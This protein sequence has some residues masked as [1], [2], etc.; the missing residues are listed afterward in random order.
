M[1]GVRSEIQKDT[2]LYFDLVDITKKYHKSME[3]IGSTWNGSEGVPGKG[4]EMVD[5]SLGMANGGMTLHRHLYSTKHLD[6]DSQVKEIEKV[7]EE[8][9]SS[10]AVAITICSLN[11]F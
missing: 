3:M 6:Y 1:I 10:I 2:P 7:L 4:Y 11:C 9:H 5:V 8:R